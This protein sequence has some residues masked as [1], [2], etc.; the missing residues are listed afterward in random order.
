MKT[1]NA[2]PLLKKYRQF[3][4]CYQ[5]DRQYHCV[6]CNAVLDNLPVVNFDKGEEIGDGSEY[7]LI[8]NGIIYHGDLNSDLDT[9][10]IDRFTPEQIEDED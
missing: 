10:R 5:A 7:L 2:F 1:K 9:H 6:D 4:K 3:Q 8:Q